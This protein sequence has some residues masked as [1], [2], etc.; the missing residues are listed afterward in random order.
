MKLFHVVGVTPEAP[1]RD[2]VFGGREPVETFPLGPREVRAGHDGLSTLDEGALDTVCIGTPH[3]SI[4]EFEQLVPMLEGE[5]IHSGLRFYVT[6]SRFVLAELEARGWRETCESA[7]VELLVDTC[8]YFPPVFAGVTG[9]VMTNSAKWA[10]YAPESL[11][12]RVAFGSLAECVRSG[13]AGRV[14]RDERRWADV[15]G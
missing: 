3:F 10:Y 9:A 7:G 11:G 14:V 5:R 2:A 6:T 8:T 4:R 15:A 1:T 12:A 13:L